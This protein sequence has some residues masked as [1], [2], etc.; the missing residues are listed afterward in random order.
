M[1]SEGPPVE[2]RAAILRLCEWKLSH[3]SVLPCG[4]AER[5]TTSAICDAPS[6]SKKSFSGAKKSASKSAFH[7]HAL[8]P[9]A[10]RYE[11]LTA[12]PRARES[13]FPS[14]GQEK[15]THPT[16]IHID[17]A[18]SNPPSGVAP[19]MPATPFGCQGAQA[20]EEN[21]SPNRPPLPPPSA[22]P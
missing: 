22:G 21:T 2:N 13:G 9:C 11:S 6:G 16:R 12:A 1:L 3:S 18:K 7:A 15:A 10:P 20:P 5:F 19:P 4:T 8:C 17:S 14:P